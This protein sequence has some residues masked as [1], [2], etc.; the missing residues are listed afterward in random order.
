[1][2]REL[3]YMGEVGQAAG[4]R[5]IPANMFAVLRPLESVVS[6]SKN[7]AL[8]PKD[9]DGFDLR[10]LDVNDDAVSGLVSK[11]PSIKILSVTDADITDKLFEKLPKMP[12]LINLSAR[13]VPITGA[14]LKQFTKFPNL[15]FV[16]LTETLIKD[17][18]CALLLACPNL[19]EVQLQRT[20]ITD[21]GLAILGKLPKLKDL[22]LSHTKV[23]ASGL[24]TM[25]KKTIET[26]CLFHVDVGDE[27]LAELGKFDRL[28]SIILRGFKRPTCSGKG[29][30]A[31]ASLKSLEY[32]DFNEADIHDDVLIAIAKSIPWLERLSFVDCK[33]ITDAGFKD[34]GRLLK[35]KDLRAGN[36]RAGD[37]FMKAVAKLPRLVVLQTGTNTT[38]AG[39][40]VLC[41]ARSPVQTLITEN[42][43]IGDKSISDLTAL[44]NLR[45]LS[46]SGNNA[47]SDA[48]IPALLR[49]KGLE[50]LAIQNTKISSAGCERL[51]AAMPN[52]RIRY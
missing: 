47:I 37:T 44:P 9:I 10:E 2:E 24:A 21:K 33:S 49:L 19:F 17:D 7:W 20:Q 3:F 52:V 13:N 1:M 32:V 48:C 39:I 28:R 38:D 31:L 6:K 43:K 40:K 14:S 29:I 45:V 36:S 16:I 4:N 26:I 41:A 5:E 30:A 18:D 11:F 27:G 42:C 50:G 46:I 35:M 25:P 34:F 23:T 51:K 8:I 12:R 15:Q 22:N